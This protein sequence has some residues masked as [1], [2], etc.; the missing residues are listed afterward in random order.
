ML[1]PGVDFTVIK[2]HDGSTG[3]LTDIDEHERVGRWKPTKLIRMMLKTSYLMRPT[4]I[5]MIGKRAS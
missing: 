4:I 5:D 1:F 3:R 2:E